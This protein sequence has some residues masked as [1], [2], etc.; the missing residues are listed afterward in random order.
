MLIKKTKYT[1]L[2][3]G[4]TYKWLIKQLHQ[5]EITV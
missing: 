2:L 3:I 1:K 5:S 4:L